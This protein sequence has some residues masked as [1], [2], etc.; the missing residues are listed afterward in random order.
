MGHHLVLVEVTVQLL[1]V[2]VLSFYRPG[3]LAMGQLHSVQSAHT[4]L[5]EKTCQRLV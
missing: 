1:E 5:E 3:E 4:D 2:L